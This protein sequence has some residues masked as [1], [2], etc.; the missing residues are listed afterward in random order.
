M[1]PMRF[2]TC[3]IETR[4]NNM[5]GLAP[6]FVESISKNTKI[7][8]LS[9]AFVAKLSSKDEIYTDL[10]WKAVQY[11]FYVLPYKQKRPIS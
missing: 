6:I 1:F 2:I 8:N 10:V 7:P 4:E 11:K 3:L 5:L 9:M